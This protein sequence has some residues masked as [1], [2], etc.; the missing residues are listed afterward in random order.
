MGSSPADACHCP[1]VDQLI[2]D[3]N[4]LKALVS[5]GKDPWSLG[6]RWEV[7]GAMEVPPDHV[8]TETSLTA[9]WQFPLGMLGSLGAIGFRDQG[10]LD[11][12][13]MLHDDFRYNGVKGGAA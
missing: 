3:V 4:T 7:R 5:D 2:D 12:K 6:L 13:L 1:H 8:P 10:M 11:D 9:T